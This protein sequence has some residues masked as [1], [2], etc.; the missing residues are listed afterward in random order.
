[1]C[2]IVPDLQSIARYMAEDRLHEPI[3][4]S[5]A[6]PITAHDMIYG[7]GPAIADG[8]T[9]MAHRCGFTPTLIIQ[10]F[11][12]LPFADILVRRRTTLELAVVARK[13]AFRD[14]VERNELID[15][16]RL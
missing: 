15:A 6:G 16:L 3:Y 12:A 10:F 5:A 11:R 2:V 8:H 1:V 13:T 7:H 14:A 4:E 9:S